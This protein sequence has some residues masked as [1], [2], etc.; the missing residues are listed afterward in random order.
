MRNVVILGGGAA[1]L[2]SAASWD[3]AANVT[4]IEKNTRPA[5]KVMITGKGRCNVTNNTDVNALILNTHR[6][7]KFL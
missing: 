4:V 6:N 5:R 1:G 3:G 7:G 2:M